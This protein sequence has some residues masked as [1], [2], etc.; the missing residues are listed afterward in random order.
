[1]STPLFLLQFLNL[2]MPSLE[3]KGADRRGQEPWVQISD[4]ICPNS[5]MLYWCLSLIFLLCEMEV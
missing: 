3:S 1:M 4:K 5:V 2:W